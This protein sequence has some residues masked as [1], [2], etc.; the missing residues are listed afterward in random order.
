LGVTAD[1]DTSRW[2]AASLGLLVDL[3]AHV[4]LETWI[5]GLF[6]GHAMNRLRMLDH[7]REDFL[8]A[9]DMNDGVTIRTDIAT[10][11]L[12]RH[13]TTSVSDN[14]N[15]QHLCIDETT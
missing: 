1:R 11:Q 9:F 12:L 4:L 2:S 7:L 10:A 3:V 14:D 5:T 8:L 15:K 13:V 6:I